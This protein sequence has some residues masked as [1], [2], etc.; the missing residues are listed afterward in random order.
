M[1]PLPGAQPIEGAPHVAQDAIL[2]REEELAAIA[3]FIDDDRSGPHALLL[4]GDAGIGKT[5]LWE[6]A[7]RLAEG[8]GLV[9]TARAAQVGTKLSFTVLGDL[10]APVLDG[11]LEGLPAGQRAALE[12]ALLLGPPSRSPPDARGV[13]LAV[14]GVLR[15]LATSGRVTIAIDDVQWTDPPSAQALCFTFRRLDDEPVAVIA[16]KRVAAGLTDPLDLA[17]LPLRGDRLTVGPIALGPLGQ[18]LRRRLGR[19][20]APPLVKRIHE[21]SG[22][23]PFFAVEIGRALGGEDPNR[24][25]GEPLPVPIDVQAHGRREEP[26]DEDPHV[27]RQVADRD[28]A[29]RIPWKGLGAACRRAER[30]VGRRDSTR[31]APAGRLDDRMCTTCSGL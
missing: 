21:A 25:P 30:T 29:R 3:R 18:L 1:G 23:N 26:V 20:F 31:L 10:L 4:E 27:G 11:T 2:G 13:S 19:H 15:V 22:G 17:R 12:A 16:A 14:L 5:T 24:R 9:L 6:E 7:V 8:T 28:A